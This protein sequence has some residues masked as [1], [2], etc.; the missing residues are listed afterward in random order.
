MWFI[1]KFCLV[2]RWELGGR[3]LC[4]QNDRSS[5]TSVSGRRERTL[6]D[7]DPAVYTFILSH[8][9]LVSCFPVSVEWNF[10]WTLEKH[11]F[12][13]SRRSP[14]TFSDKLQAERLS[15]GS[16]LILNSKEDCSKWICNM[17]YSEISG[18]KDTGHISL[19]FTAAVLRR[20]CE[21]AA[22]F[23]L[24]CCTAGK[25]WHAGLRAEGGAQ[26]DAGGGFH[27]NFSR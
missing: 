6:T 21:V 3:F 8:P 25:R 18:L 12:G 20:P 26:T 23:C 14:V 19:S 15:Q 2:C 24:P 4:H 13:F 5:G 10:H 16:T 22:V 9:D 1:W 7:P 27:V 17:F 11:L